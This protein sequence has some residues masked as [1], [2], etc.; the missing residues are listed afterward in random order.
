MRR[1]RECLHCHK[2]F[3]TYEK[4]EFHFLVIK[5]DGRLESFTLQKIKNSLQKA[6]NKIDEESLLALT[7]KIEQKILLRKTNRLKTS[8]IG[9]TVLGE[10]K[11]FDA[12]AYVR[13]ATVHKGIDNPKTLKKELLQL[14]H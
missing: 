3:T 6:C 4:A 11:K 13:Y 14:I 7:K 5:K 8:D 2:R 1:R 10:L 9:K 12:I